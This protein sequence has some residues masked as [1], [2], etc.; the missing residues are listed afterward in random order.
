METKGGDVVV[1][2]PIEGL[3]RAGKLNRL[4]YWILMHHAQIRTLGELA[5]WSEDEFSRMPMIGRATTEHVKA[6]MAEYGLMFSRESRKSER[7]R[8]DEGENM[9]TF[10]KWLL[11][12]VVA[13]L[14][15]RSYVVIL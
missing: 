15:W 6:L 11:G 12:V 13:Y 10:E 8:S 1:L 5:N 4:A 7:W 2:L 9:T 3:H 14:L